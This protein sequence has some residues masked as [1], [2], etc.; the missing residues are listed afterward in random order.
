MPSSKTK[1][2][3]DMKKF[4]KKYSKRSRTS[5]RYESDSEVSDDGKSYEA[6]SD[7]QYE[8]YRG[9]A[10]KK[11]KAKKYLNDEDSDDTSSVKSDSDA[12]VIDDYNKKKKRYAYSNDSRSEKSNSRRSRSSESGYS[13]DDPEQGHAVDESRHK[14]RYEDAVSHRIDKF[15]RKRTA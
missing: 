6:S 14:K 15:G 5:K 7:D 11:R 9:I 10:N 2:L 4:K 8:Q 13:K 12:D 3:S 1:P